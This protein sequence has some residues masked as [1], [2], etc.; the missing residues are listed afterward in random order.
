M[1]SGVK[2]RDPLR[3]SEMTEFRW[4]FRSTRLIAGELGLPS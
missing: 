4:I 2:Y 1:I 3:A